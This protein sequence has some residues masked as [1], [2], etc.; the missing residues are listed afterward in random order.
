[1]A[2]TRI[3]LRRNKK[4]DHHEERR[5]RTTNQQSREKKTVRYFQRLRVGRDYREPFL[6]G[7]LFFFPLMNEPVHWHQPKVHREKRKEFHIELRKKSTTLKSNY[8]GPRNKQLLHL[9]SFIVF[10]HALHKYI[11][12]RA[13]STTKI[14]EQNGTNGNVIRRN[15]F[16]GPYAQIDAKN[17]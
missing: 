5:F 13:T 2:K 14:R 17:A 11:S 1:M 10:D 12:H 8:M 6:N 9:S 7:N 3:E 15:E 4:S 16:M